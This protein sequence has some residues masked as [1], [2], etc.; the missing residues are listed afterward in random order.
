MNYY[1]ALGCARSGNAECALSYLRS[2][3]DEGFVTR[4][5]AAAAAEFASLRENPKFQQ[6]MTEPTAQ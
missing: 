3:L 4:K 5:K 2:A 6:L 1:M